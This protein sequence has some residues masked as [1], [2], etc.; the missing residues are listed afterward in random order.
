MRKTFVR[1]LGAAIVANL[2]LAATSMDHATRITIGIVVGLPAF[3]LLLVTRRQLGESFAV[4][5]RA[6]KLVTTG[7]Y[8]RIQHPM[9]VFLDIFL[10]SLIVLFDSPAFVLPWAALVVLQGFQAWREQKLLTEAFGAE[11]EA[12]ESQTWL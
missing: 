8:S 3:V 4:V 1:L 6:K 10:L 5:P 9:Y 11:Y 7:L 2:A 12:Y